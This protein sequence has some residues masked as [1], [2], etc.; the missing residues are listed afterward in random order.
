M[1]YIFRGNLLGYLCDDCYEAIAGNKVLLYLPLDQERVTANAVADTKDTFHQVTDD[2]LKKKEKLLIA[3]AV[4]D[5]A[6]NFEFVLDEK[7]ANTAFD[8]D[9]ECGTVPHHIPG[10]KK[11]PF[12]QF[13]LTTVYPQWRTNEKEDAVYRF[14]Y[15]IPSKW[16]C[17]I[18]GHYFDAW[19]ICGQI[20]NCETG[21]VFPNVK[22]TAWDADFITD[23]N[24]GTA[25]TDASGH[26]RI[27]YTSAKF[28]K[29]FLSP[30]INVETDKGLPLT[31]HSG[32][33]VYF[34]AVIGT[35]KIVDE[36]SANRRKNVGFCLC[37]D[38]CSKVQGPNDG[39][40]PPIPAFLKI[41][42]LDYET[43]IQSHAG[44][45]GL[46]NSNYAFYSSLRLN[47]ILAQK[48]N[49]V[50]MEYCFEYTNQYNGS[51]NPV[52]WVRVLPNQIAATD[53]GYVEKA[54]LMPADLFHP[55]PWYK[56]T[57]KYCIVT[58][59][60][61]NPNQIQV[62][63]AADG[64]IAVPQQDDDPQNELG[65]G[66]FVANG[67]QIVLN[68]TTLEAFP[69]IDLTGLVAGNSS[70]STG[71]ALA[72]DKV[73]A[74]RMLVREQGSGTLFE[75]GRCTRLAIDNTL[76]NGMKH[77]PEWGAWGPTTEYGVCM[78]DVKQLQLVGCSKIT[79]QADILFTCAHPN[80]G[81][82][83]ATLTGPGGIETLV[84]PP[85]GVTGDKHGII[86]KTFTSADPACAY[87]VTLTTTYLLTTGDN[88]YPSV[89]DQIAF[90]R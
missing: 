40:N 77:H 46:S 1:K 13:H 29:T 56:F 51:G 27:D 74:L 53:I 52:S 88:H 36:T 47:G 23:D 12:L 45:S 54:K 79:D 87:L 86:T 15:A 19:V 28:K 32:P 7:H 65:T 41:G 66:L 55:F 35:T 17:H 70:T 80:L 59:D 30:V 60:P 48:L 49:G 16:W 8:I 71:K 73:Y 42:G 62:P 5:E 76:Y 50:T 21:A 18:R 68:S 83:S 38:L 63:I 10:R 43:D 75:A 82:I 37:V 39:T 9:F 22:V 84:V 78:V 85:T 57:Y 44:Q 72:T 14:S 6:G 89:H 67:N 11:I 61:V 34:K 2:E 33:D 20:R 90:C 4:T 58:N 26:F 31:F 25:V 24:L 3:T 69:P 64:W 81:A